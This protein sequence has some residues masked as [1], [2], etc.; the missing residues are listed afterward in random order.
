[1]S[2]E[3]KRSFSYD[4]YCIICGNKLWV[5]PPQTSVSQPGG[6]STDGF[7]QPSG[8]PPTTGVEISPTVAWPSHPEAGWAPLEGQ[9][10]YEAHQANEQKRL[11][12]SQMRHAKKHVPGGQTT[13]SSTAKRRKS[14]SENSIARMLAAR[15]TKMSAMTTLT[16][17]I[18]ALVESCIFRPLLWKFIL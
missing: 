2:E 15:K 1:L 16:G 17:L 13:K 7:T 3:Q 4:N 14:P 11:A 5:N 18:R 12:R 6:S 9:V 10:G 8:P